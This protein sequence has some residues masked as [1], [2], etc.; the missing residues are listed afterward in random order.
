M[1]NAIMD[2]F[3]QVPVGGEGSIGKAVGV[4]RALGHPGDEACVVGRVFQW[5]GDDGIAV[6][7]E[8]VKESCGGKHAGSF[9]AM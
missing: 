2:G 4:L 6:L 3:G 8:V 1:L 9:G 7:G 5:V